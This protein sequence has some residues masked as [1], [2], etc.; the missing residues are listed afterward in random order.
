MMS[1]LRAFTMP[2]WGIEMT[3]GVLAEWLVAEGEAFAKGQVIAAIETDK[4]V[5][6]VEADYDA[7]CLRL[8]AKPET[9]H[10]V[11]ALLAV[12]GEAG[13]GAAEID[14]FIGEFSGNAVDDL[15]ASEPAGN[16]VE[17]MAVEQAVAEVVTQ[18]DSEQ[19]TVAPEVL[20]IPEGVRISS[21]A[22][23]LAQT[24]GVDLTE[25]SGSGNRGRILV[26]DVEQAVRGGGLFSGNGAAVDNSFTADAEV[27]ER[28]T[29]IAFKV[30][31]NAG[32][33]WSQLAGSGKNQRIRLR[34]LPITEVV[35]QEPEFDLG[36]TAGETK[37]IPFSRMRGHVADRLTR[38]QNEIPHYFLEIDVDANQLVSA[39]AEYNKQAS[40]HATVNDVVLLAVARCL[41]RHQQVNINVIDDEIK[42]FADVNLAIAVSI[43]DGLITPVIKQADSLNLAELSSEARRLIDGARASTLSLADYGKG[44]FTVSN[45]G[46]HGIKRFTS[47][48]NPPQAAILSVG[49]IRR[50]IQESSAGPVFGWRM[51]LTMACD[52]RAIDGTIGTSMLAS[53]KSQLEAP[54]QLFA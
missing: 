14:K 54:Q 43:D 47:I 8:I 30:A 26:Q 41:A 9:E 12:F 2:K 25:L 49:Q 28:I 33:D 17:E 19:T 3:E 15:S 29:P 36:L 44:T 40:A 37:T 1:K 27:L 31:E 5:N 21:K 35:E 42:Y 18:P 48:I 46:M 38:S 51:S 53:I 45:L 34:D 50:A 16:S 20:E 22:A 32:L 13:V 6:E 24:S 23:E 52:H 4:I 7:V 10:V 11:G 39:R